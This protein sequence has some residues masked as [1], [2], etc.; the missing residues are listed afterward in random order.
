MVETALR[1]DSIRISWHSP[2]EVQHLAPDDL[3]WRIVPRPHVWRPPTDVYDMDDAIVVRVE[4]AG[5]REEDFEISL[6]DRF[7][8][9]RGVRPDVSEKRAYYQMEIPFGEFSTEVELPYP[10]ITDQI[11]A[12]YRDGFL[13]IV[14]PKVQP[15]QIQIKD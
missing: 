2:E 5:V 3:R 14:L 10:V 1:T 11:Q 4:V 8:S 12:V 13:R 15:R 9:I 6:E 7:L